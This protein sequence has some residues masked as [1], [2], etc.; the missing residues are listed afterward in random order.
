MIKIAICDDEITICSNLES[1]VG[2]YLRSR[3]IQFKIDI[4][5]SAESILESMNRDFSYDILFLDIEMQGLSGIDFGKKLRTDMRNEVLKIIY[6]SWEA[7]YAMNLFEV[8]PMD[9]MIKP[10]TEDKV[11]KVLDVAIVLIDREMQYFHYQ[12][13]N[14]HEK[15]LLREI[16]YFES[17][18]RKIVMH[19]VHKK[20]EFYG[21]LDDVVSK[22]DGKYF[23]RIHKSFLINHLYIK[24]LE[25]KQVLMI[26]DVI[27]KISRDQQSTIRDMYFSLLKE[28]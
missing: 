28:N 25:F 9:F 21:R 11:H 13:S 24:R 2:T 27:L 14:Y 1:I 20:I 4:F 15:V 23:W 3:N 7:S 12:R 26:N 18:N 22:T 10:L 16:L 6:I 8:R 5:Y 19:T 17:I